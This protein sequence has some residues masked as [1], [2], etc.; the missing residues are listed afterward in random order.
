[1][2]ILPFKQARRYA[3]AFLNN[4]DKK[5]TQE[6]LENFEHFLHFLQ[7]NPI[8]IRQFSSLLTDPEIQAKAFG[9]ITERFNLGKPGEQLIRVLLEHKR[10]N[11]L[12][13]I[14]TL[15]LIEGQKRRQE[16]TCEVATSHNLSQASKELLCSTLGKKL[17]G[18]I[19]PSYHLDST[20]I[21]GIRVTGKTFLW[22]NSIAKKLK[23]LQAFIAR[24]E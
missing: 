3:Q 14:V 11:L 24:Q 9:K 20:L 13:K 23:A 6:F 17:G 1:M 4:F 16:F 18:I 15:I 10:I 22:E 8:I 2:Y 7:T 12:T 19:K 21:Q 5:S